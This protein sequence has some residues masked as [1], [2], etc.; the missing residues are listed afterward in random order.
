MQL[1]V[2]TS[3]DAGSITALITEAFRADP[4][5]SWAMSRPDG[6]THHHAALWRIFVDGAVR[7]PAT[8]T[9]DGYEAVSVWIPPGGTE[10]S[11]DQEEDLVRTAREVLGPRA[12]EY[13]ELLDRFDEAH[14]R[15]EPH[16]YLSLLATA[17]AAR[18]R[19]LGMALLRANLDT[20]DNHGQAAYLESSNPA[21]DHRYESV[22]FEKVGEFSAPGDGP[23]VST[24]WR[25]AR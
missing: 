7:Y 15:D 6:T 11:A 13:L 8:W 19:G 14:P 4:L 9:T 21:N 18:G 22:G 3:D 5:W 17:S 2:A 23:R 16:H 10:V 25:G 24:M 12:D 1:R 20:L